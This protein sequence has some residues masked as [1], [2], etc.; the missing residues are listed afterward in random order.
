MMNHPVDVLVLCLLP[1]PVHVVPPVGAPVLPNP[2]SLLAPLFAGAPVSI[3]LAAAAVPAYNLV[4]QLLIFPY[5]FFCWLADD[6]VLVFVSL[7][8]AAKKQQF[9]HETLLTDAIKLSHSTPS[10]SK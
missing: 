5:V 1:A 3:A 10:S 8:R 4:Q 9:V 2:A 6:L 7:L